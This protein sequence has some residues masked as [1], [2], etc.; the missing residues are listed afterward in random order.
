[1]FTAESLEII[2]WRWWLGKE[3]INT[4]E[5]IY[6]KDQETSWWHCLH[7]ERKTISISVGEK[8]ITRYMKSPSTVAGLYRMGRELEQKQSGV[9]SGSHIRRS[10]YLTLI[11]MTGD[12]EAKNT[13]ESIWNTKTLERDTSRIKHNT[14]T[15]T[16]L[17]PMQAQAPWGTITFFTSPETILA[18]GDDPGTLELG[19]HDN[20]L[21]KLVKQNNQNHQN[22]PTWAIHRR[23]DRFCQS[24]CSEKASLRVQKIKA[25]W[26]QWRSKFWDRKPTQSPFALSKRE[27][28]KVG[29]R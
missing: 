23:N 21:R 9:V 7:L 12:G 26:N 2:P 3:T 28:I 27:K 1:M 24:S 22:T 6:H 11:M 20:I 13:G 17:M 10:R 15:L 4:G 18:L 19:S 25:R 5:E 14:K 16:L 8:N 29:G